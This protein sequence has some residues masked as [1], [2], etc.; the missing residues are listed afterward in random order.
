MMTANRVPTAFRRAATA[1][2]LATGI[3]LVAL[4][5]PAQPLPAGRVELAQR[6]TKPSEP[7]PLPPAPPPVQPRAGVTEG[8]QPSAPAPAPTPPPAPSAATKPSAA[9]APMRVVFEKNAMVLSNEARAVLDTVVS[10][11][12]ADSTLRAMLK[13]YSSTG[14]STSEM[15]RMSLKR[16]TLVRDYLML[17]GIPSIRIDIQALGSSPDDGPADRVDVVA[18]KKS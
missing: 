3:A 7:P 5:A 12:K 4:P 13:S 16:G 2:V 11:L 6:V 17:K 18:D 14:T 10:T 8:P 1:A 9:P 15:R